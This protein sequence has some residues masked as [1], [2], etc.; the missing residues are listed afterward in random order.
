MNIP[1]SGIFEASKQKLQKLQGQNK[2]IYRK[3]N[4]L[5]EFPVETTETTGRK[6]TYPPNSFI[7]PYLNYTCVE[8]LKPPSKNYRNYKVKMNAYIENLNCSECFPVE[9]TETTGQ[10]Q[11]YLLEF[12]DFP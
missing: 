7:L 10:K 6:R 5:G 3:S 11:I 8:N 1:P 12:F 4:L 9:T 2:C